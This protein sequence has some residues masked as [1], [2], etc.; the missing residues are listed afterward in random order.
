MLYLLLVIFILVATADEDCRQIRQKCEAITRRILDG[1]ENMDYQQ[2][3]VLK[4]LEEQTKHCMREQKC[5]I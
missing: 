2:H 3:M 5:N 1:E 4:E